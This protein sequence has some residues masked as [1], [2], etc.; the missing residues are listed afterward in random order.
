MITSIENYVLVVT[1]SIKDN[2]KFLENI[3]N[4]LKRSIFWNRCRSEKAT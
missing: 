1:L 4:A 2:I 3:K